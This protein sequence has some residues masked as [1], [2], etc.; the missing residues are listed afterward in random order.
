MLKKL[1]AFGL[2]T[3]M[4]LGT[5]ISAFA[6]ES[7]EA[8]LDS[9]QIHES[10]K[11]FETINDYGFNLTKNER[12]LQLISE[13]EYLSEVLENKDKIYESINGKTYCLDLSVVDLLDIPN[14]KEVT[15]IS[16]IEGLYYSIAY[17]TTDGEF[18]TVQYL[19]D[20]T[21]NCY[22]RNSV[23]EDTVTVYNEK[24]E[25]VTELTWSD[26]NYYVSPI[27]EIAFLILFSTFCISMLCLFDAVRKKNQKRKWISLLIGLLA[28]VLAIGLLA[29]L[30]GLS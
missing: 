19:K 2:A 27:V 29:Y 6:A 8:I 23:E 26:N 21:K 28:A 20:G 9:V 7:D 24:K 22:V 10:N 5:T 4:A 15:E 12:S 1:F 16:N 3:I 18:V 17:Y 13:Y 30:K 11:T 14:L 25:T